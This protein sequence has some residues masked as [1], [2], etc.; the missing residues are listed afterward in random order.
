MTK[1]VNNPFQNNQPLPI[2]EYTHVINGLTKN[3]LLIYLYIIYNLKCS[4]NEVWIRDVITA[5]IMPL[6]SHNKAIKELVSKSIIDLKDESQ[7]WI[8]K[9]YFTWRN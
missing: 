4:D 7:F 8:N 6:R 9:S 5:S 1:K 2:E 3:A